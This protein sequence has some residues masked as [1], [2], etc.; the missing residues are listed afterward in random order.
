[1]LTRLRIQN[2]KSWADTGEIS[3]APLTGL[4]G[5]NSSGKTAI[6][7]LLLLLK[8]TVESTHLSR[9]LHLGSTHSP[10]PYV[11]LG[12][13]AHVLHNHQIPGK[14]QVDFSWT[15]LD[16]LDIVYPEEGPDST[17]FDIQKLDF[18]MSIHGDGSRYPRVEQ[19]YYQSPVGEPFFRCGMRKKESELSA[20]RGE[21]PG[22]EGQG[23]WPPDEYILIVDSDI[24]Q[25]SEPIVETTWP[26]PLKFYDFSNHPTENLNSWRKL[27]QAFEK[28]LRHVY[29][30]GP[31]REPL[32]KI[33]RAGTE[34][35]DIGQRGEQALPILL[36]PQNEPVK[37]KVT[38]WLCELALLDSFIV[39]PLEDDG[40]LLGNEVWVRHISDAAPVLLADV[41]F[42]V[43]QILPVLTLC[44]YVPEGST[45]ILE[46]PEIHLHPKAQAGLADVFI[47]VI[48]TRNVQI[49]LESHSEHLLHRLQ[50]RIAEEEIHQPESDTQRPESKQIA[51]YFIDNPEGR[52]EICR[53]ALDPF[54]SISNWPQDFFGDDLGDLI[55][56]T[57]AAIRRQKAQE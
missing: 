2:F 38:E 20:L 46:Q 17:L 12:T 44:A 32:Q 23:S 7:Q 40:Q 43:S 52:S 24:K 55:K 51:L 26:K 34:A 30:L 19:F 11:N 29:Y 41:G 57:K 15:L 1:M 16:P 14:L 48:K 4:F 47:D 27:V 49:I 36:A 37:E 56:M 22:F 6:L 50:R 39:R 5:V 33:Y 31:L 9:P 21:I 54:G 8:Q 28:Q 53:L 45:L 42:G 10:G 13:M 35:A 18:H 3:L 25:M